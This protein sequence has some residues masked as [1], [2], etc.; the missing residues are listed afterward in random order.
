MSCIAE[1]Y[2]LVEIWFNFFRRDMSLIFL[3]VDGLRDDRIARRIGVKRLIIKLMLPVSSVNFSLP[4]VLS[5]A[6]VYFACPR[7]CQRPFHDELD[8][9][10]K[11]R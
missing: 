5:N 10:F 9:W 11:Q 7:T 6:V 3:R 2:W 8:I 4:T 1:I